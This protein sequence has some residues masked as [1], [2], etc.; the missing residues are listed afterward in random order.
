MLPSELLLD[1]LL[2]Q[3]PAWQVNRPPSEDVRTLRVS[4]HFTSIEDMVWVRPDLS[5]EVTSTVSPSQTVSTKAWTRSDV[6]FE[7]VHSAFSTDYVYRETFQPGRFAV[8][9]KRMSV[10]E[11]LTQL[12]TW[13]EE[14]V[15]GDRETLAITLEVLEVLQTQLKAQM[16]PLDR[17]GA[18]LTLQMPGEIVESNA[19]FAAGNQCA[20]TASVADLDGG[21][22]VYARSRETN[23]RNVGLV[24]GGGLLML[25]LVAGGGL[26]A[27]GRTREKKRGGEVEAYIGVEEEGFDEYDVADADYE[28]WHSEEEYDSDYT[29]DD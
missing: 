2:P 10:E 19:Q 23:M 28:E 21:F 25:L 15:A 1:D 5:S 9:L 13:A 6:S 16:V 7:I 11:L 4:G 20:W 24:G 26:I 8:P 29:Y 14:L 27:W 18:N 22:E 12:A 17:V 3:G